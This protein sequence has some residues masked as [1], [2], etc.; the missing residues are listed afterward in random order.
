MVTKMFPNKRMETKGETSVKN[1]VEE[2][3]NKGNQ[4]LVNPEGIDL[5]KNYQSNYLSRLLK[6]IVIKIYKLIWKVGG[7][8]VVNFV[9]F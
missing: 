7:N 2:P 5:R 6:R 3:S 1:R 8:A 9:F 4:E